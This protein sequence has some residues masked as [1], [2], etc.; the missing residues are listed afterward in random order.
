MTRGW[1]RA[2]GFY[3][4]GVTS[5]GTTIPELSFMQDLPVTRRAVAFA[6][7]RHSG[8]RRE[9]D[10]APFLLH[11]LEVASLL[12]RE[13]WS[14]EVIAAAVLHD[15]LEDTDAERSELV[16]HFGPEVGRL[17][18]LVTDDPAI[19][20]EEQ[21]KDEVRERVRNAGNDALAVYA[22][23]KISKVRELRMLIARGRS[24]NEAETKH[25]RYR[26]SLRMLGHEL[27]DSRLVAAL[28]FELEALEQLPP[29]GAR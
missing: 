5:V 27:G 9:A 4:H 11:P 20:G 10:G 23:D 6:C 14:D 16:A 15:V 28:Q 17:V 13:S 2:G 22:A 1:E 25:H 7:E 29:T 21:R 3:A 19:E 18:A 24:A 12:E 8:Q 26:E